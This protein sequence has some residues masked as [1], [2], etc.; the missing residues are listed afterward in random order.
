MAAINGATAQ[1]RRRSWHH[2]RDVRF[3]IVVGVIL[4]LYYGYGYATGPA[5]ISDGLHARLDRGDGRVNIRVTSKFAPEAFHMGVY[6]EIGSVR[7]TTGRTVTLYKV[8][9][10]DVRALSRRYW[11]ERID[12]ARPSNSENRS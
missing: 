1:F 2:R 7:G 12:L 11:I 6:Q 4:G 10:T 5:R 9:P 3:L 8:D